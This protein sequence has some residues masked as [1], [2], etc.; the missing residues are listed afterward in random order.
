MQEWFDKDFTARQ[1]YGR[2]FK[3][4]GKYRWALAM[5]IISG[6]MLA[7]TLV[8]IYQVLK[9]A[10][11]QM[12]S[13]GLGIDIGR[14]AEDGSVKPADGSVKLAADIRAK[15]A[16]PGWVK[17]VE[18]VAAR[19]G[20]TVF[21]DSGD[22]RGSFFLLVLLAVPLAFVFR[23]G[24]L[25][26]NSYTLQW[27]GARVVRDLRNDM[28][29]HLQNQSLKFFGTMDVGRIM[30]RCNGDPL[31]VHIVIAQTVVELCKAPFEI[32]ASIGFVAYF[33]IKNDMLEMIGLALVGYPL[34]IW[35]LATIG[36]KIR[37]YS[38]KGLERGAI[39]GSNMLENLTGIRVVKAYHT[40]EEEKEK[41]KRSN[42]ECVK[43][44]LRGIRISL[45]INPMM[46]GVTILL[47]ILFFAI[48]FWRGK[49]FAEI[50]PLLT[51][52]VMAYKPLKSIGKIQASIEA[53][54]AALTRI[55]SFLDMDTALPVAEHPVAK[56]SFDT[57]MVFEHVDFSYAVTDRKVVQDANFVLGRG[58]TIAVVGATGSGKT[59][60]A[61][62]LVRFYDPTQG[63]VLM[64][65]VDLREMDMADLR[66]L[67]GVVTQETILF[68]TTI[69]ENIAY[70]TKGA[71]QDQIEQAAKL[72][73]AHAFI[74]AHP[75]GYRR[76]VG[77]KGFVLS[78]GERQR[79][80]VARAILKNPPILILDEA[81]SALD[82]VTEQQVQEAITRLME[83]RTVFVIA[84]RLST[85]RHAD[86]ILVM[87]QGRIIEKGS[88]DALYAAGG[89]YQNLCDVQKSVR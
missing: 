23:L 50:I 54:R 65:G 39:L 8:P 88:H 5:G 7:G 82:T 79:V 12:Q 27:A 33:A 45:L 29:A 69:A 68:N 1:V 37:V 13:G 52:L 3:Q 87:D 14:P 72:A 42:Q 66:K 22:V 26:L 86:T 67:I 85:V 76:I 59:T 32:L 9:P 15:G 80:A 40:E 53:G 75:D 55:Y 31:T 43:V 83:N 49:T 38:R 11:M 16:M 78:G 20:I 19:C 47:A 70:G 73:N 44:A 4:A 84:H 6:V 21:N 51:P 48:C 46:E 74:I 81:T 24:L 64:D 60:L 17:K 63:R 18:Q 36:K 71:T 2:L 61:N 30:S 56:K 89:V 10:I 57:N 28:F 25:Y 41:F 62:L 77:D 35:P 34:V 58:Q